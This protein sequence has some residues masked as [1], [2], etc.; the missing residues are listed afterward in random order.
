MKLCERVKWKM[1]IQPRELP[2]AKGSAV[3]CCR[4]AR[5]HVRHANDSLKTAIAKISPLRRDRRRGVGKK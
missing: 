5:V 4:G 3:V 1:K 2:A